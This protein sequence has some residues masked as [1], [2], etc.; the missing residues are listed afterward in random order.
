MLEL[1]KDS[2]EYLPSAILSKKIRNFNEQGAK[3]LPLLKSATNFL[4]LD[5]SSQTFDKSFKDLCSA[6]EPTVLNIIS[7]GEGEDETFAAMMETLTNE[8]YVKVPVNELISLENERRTEFGRVF[9]QNISTG[10]VIPSEDIVRFLRKVLYSGDGHKKYILSGDFPTSTEQVKEFEKSC[11]SISAVIY[12]GTKREDMISYNIPNNMLRV[13][14]TKSLFL[15][16]NRLQVVSEWDSQNWQEV[17][18]SV[19][20][21]WCLVTGAPFSG[22][23]TVT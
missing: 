20:V 6:V 4:E 12:S 14:E 10:K 22:K 13:F 18:A 1:S 11:A 21:D 3:L 8:G 9:M 17:F 7:H 2:P 15:K 23:T 5:T 16:E 19:K